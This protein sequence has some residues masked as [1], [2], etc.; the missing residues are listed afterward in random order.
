MSLKKLTISIVV[1]VFHE[2]SLINTM[3]RDLQI[4]DVDYL[5]EVIV[6]DCIGDTVDA[7]NSS[8]ASWEKL[9]L[10]KTKSQ[11]RALQMNVGAAHATGDILL[12]L[13]VDTKL[14]QNAYFSIIDLLKPEIYDAGAFDMRFDVD[15]WFYRMIE[16]NISIRS[17]LTKTPYGDQAIFV[18]RKVF[19]KLKGY[20]PLP[21]FEDVDFCRRLKKLK[22][23]IG[24]IKNHVITS[25]RRYEKCWFCT[26]TRNW[27][28]T[29][30]YYFG[31]D[32][33]WLAKFYNK[34]I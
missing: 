16:F 19:Q 26:L 30:L 7:V 31:A 1:P 23:K 14:P 4:F 10:V 28:I 22:F 12:F 15:N 5:L 2:A 29:V 17:R 6:V 24:F 11:G 34:K 8:L 9:Q 32:V 25:A 21:I 13:H 27:I 18:R 33:N 3:L 20:H